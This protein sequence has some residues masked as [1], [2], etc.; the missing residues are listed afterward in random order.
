MT[1]QVMS[2]ILTTRHGPSD[3]FIVDRGSLDRTFFTYKYYLDQE[4]T[5]EEYDALYTLLSLEYLVPDMLV[6]M[7]TSPEESI[8]RRGGEGRYVT[9]ENMKY[10]NKVL[11]D[12]LNAIPE[13]FSKTTIFRLD[14]TNLNQD[15]VVKKVLEQIA[16]NFSHFKNMM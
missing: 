4:C 12:F 14:T 6:A 3:I 16:L 1:L 9:L 5:K 7:T 2:S 10:Y 15:E 8:A 13:R 11:E